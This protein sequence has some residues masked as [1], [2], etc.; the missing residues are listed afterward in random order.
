MWIIITYLAN[1]LISLPISCM[2]VSIAVMKSI[3]SK[4]FDFILWDKFLEVEL[5]G[6]RIHRYFKDFEM[7]YKI[8]SKK[9]IQFQFPIRI[10]G[11]AQILTNTK[12]N[13]CYVY[14]CQSA[15]LKNFISFYVYSLVRVNTY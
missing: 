2:Y 8:A 9:G 7:H 14:V 1:L 5:L 4:W 13:Y 10:C 6:Q 3:C 12:F 15:R 11:N